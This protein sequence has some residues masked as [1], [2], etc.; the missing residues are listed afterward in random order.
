M[1]KRIRTR[2]APSPT[3]PQHIGGIRTALYNYLVAKKAGGDFILRIEDTDSSRYVPESEE[4]ILEA[5]KWAG[6]KPD[7]GI[8]IDQE[9]TWRVAETPT[10]SNPHGSYRQ[11]QRKKIYYDEALKLL[12]SDKAYM[13]FDTPE[14][15][16]KLREE[17][18][19][20]GKK[21]SYNSQTRKNLKNSLALEKEEVDKLIAD[22]ADWVIRFKMPEEDRIIEIHDEI[23]GDIKFHTNTLD[24]KVLWKSSDELPTY[25]LA[26]VVDDHLMEITDVIRGEEWL[27]SLPL[28]ILLYE[29]FGWEHPRFSHLPLLLKPA[30]MGPGKLSKRDG[31]AGGFPVFP[32]SWKSK[33]INVSGY[34]EAGYFPEAFVNFLA[35]LGWNPGDSSEIKS[36]DELIRDF[37]IDR[38]QKAG[39]RFNPKK[40]A[41]YNK[42]YLKTK[43]DDEIFSLV[44]PLLVWKGY[45]KLTNEYVMRIVKLLRNRVSFP[46][47]IIEQGEVFLNDPTGIKIKYWNEYEEYFSD[48][49]RFFDFIG[50]AKWKTV[51]ELR[52]N[53]NGYIEGLVGGWK[54]GV[55]VINCF[56]LFISGNP[57]GPDIAET[58]DILGK[59]VIEKRRKLIK[60]RYGL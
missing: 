14:E 34:R 40:T 38:C 25:H 53:I 11:S 22:R 29:A 27:P 5:L 8:V 57:S 59:P 31:E 13:A 28:H 33:E 49:I 2:F 30:E 4:Y 10:P 37:S 19:K 9:G 52:E 3:G 58:I 54:I 45:G 18:D 26:N 60:D 39:A 16:E 21:F 15:I 23:R 55:K 50:S 42:E 17:Y 1:S 36:M 51:E 48:A 7:E 43:S 41:W 20:E 32:I 24:D 46:H 35:Y 47:E 6:I 56:R 12:L 44:R